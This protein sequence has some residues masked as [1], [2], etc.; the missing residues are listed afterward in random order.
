MEAKDL[1]DA[2]LTIDKILEGTHK[3]CDQLDDLR[4]CLIHEQQALLDKETPC[5]DMPPSMQVGQ[6]DLAVLKRLRH[7]ALAEDRDSFEFKGRKL[8]VSYAKYVIEYF[9]MAFSGKR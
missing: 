9:D 3:Q 8:L 1:R 2:L 6:H 7:K 4:T 5:S